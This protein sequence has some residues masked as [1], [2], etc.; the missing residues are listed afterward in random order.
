ME[1]SIR[2]INTTDYT[3][4]DGQPILALRDIVWEEQ[5]DLFLATMIENEVTEFVFTCTW[6]E[7]VG[8]MHDLMLNGW[9]VDSP[10]TIKRA[11]RYNDEFEI[12]KGVK[13]VRHANSNSNQ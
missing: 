8:F 1:N 10:V 9:V 5:L 12:R 3:T 2:F 6:T 7:S 13:L 11:Y 4:M